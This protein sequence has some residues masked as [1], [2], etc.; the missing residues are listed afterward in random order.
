MKVS[1]KILKISAILIIVFLI[2]LFTAS[3][4][5]QDKVAVILLKSINSNISTRIDIGSFRLSFL[6]KFPRASLELKNVLVHSSSDFNPKGFPLTG[7]DTL[8]SANSVSVEFSMSDILKG[9]YNIDRIGIKSGKLNLLSDSTGGI[10]YELKTKKK[11]SKNSEFELNLERITLSDMAAGYYNLAT[12]L[13]LQGAIKSGRFKS[14]ISDNGIDFSANSSVHITLFQLYNTKITRDIDAQLDVSLYNSNNKTLFRKGILKVENLEFGLTGIVSADNYLDLD[15]TGQNIDISKVRKFLPDN[16]RSSLNNYDPS[17]ILKINAQIE[18]TLSR[19]INPHIKITALLDNGHIENGK[20]NISVDDLS[21][22]GIFSNGEKSRPETSSLSINNISL[23]LGSS[24]LKGSFNLAHFD[25]PEASI[26]LKGILIPSELKEF[27][28]LHTFSKTEGSIDLDLKSRGKIARKKKYSLT[29]FLDLK[30]EADLKFNSFGLGMENGKF[31]VDNVNGIIRVSD[32]ITADNLLLTYKDHIIKINGEF[33]NLPERLAGRSGQKM[34]VT[35]DVALNRLD[36]AQLFSENKSNPQSLKKRSFSM[37]ADMILDLNFSV[38]SFH[39]KTFNGEKIKGRLNYSPNALIF[40]SIILNSLGGVISGNGAIYQNTDKSVI[41]RGTINIEGIDIH[42]TFITFNNFGQDFLKA[43]NL[44]GTLSGSLS[45]LLPMD[46]F[47]KPEIKSLTA[48]GK[49]TVTNG[50]LINFDPVKRLSSYIKLSELEN[51]SFET[52]KNDFFIRNNFLYIP[53]MDVKSS[54]VELSVNGKHSFDNDYV[55][56][57]KMLLSEILSKKFRKGRSFQSEFG[58][59]EDDGLGRTSLLL[60]IES[61]GEDVKVGYDVK[62][63]VSE[64]K[65]NIKE[66]KKS[67][68]TILN[69]EYGWFKSDTSIHKSEEKRPRFRITWDESGD[70]VKNIPEIPASRK[71]AP[72]K[73]LFK[74]K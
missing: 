31:T 35:A 5:L 23:K 38:E 54:A 68:K 30:T 34:T 55:Y 19:T 58:P 29:D 67:L 64:I 66:E 25:F 15:V 2:I 12:K 56:H 59:V 3:L 65:N 24:E 32:I 13:F 16:L 43:E 22:A 61:K 69:E 33:R 60:K 39:Y 41:A 20:S 27:F 18:G 7:T 45:V 9:H 40:K 28:N 74:N 42:N 17:G 10:N 46:A 62:A 70:S 14:K 51:I 26:V 6:K 44:A 49:Y 57:V 63:A 48:E 47:L 72:V 8:L 71:S 1:L 36:P 11:S 21:F 73:N 53:Q 50:A 52:L 4:L 37:P